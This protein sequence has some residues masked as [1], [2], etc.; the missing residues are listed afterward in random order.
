MRARDAI[1]PDP[2]TVAPTTTLLQFVLAVLDGNQ[3]TA[4]VVDAGRLVGVVSV[5]DVFR[6]LLPHYVGMT[7]SLATILHESY[8][9]EVF[10]RF[11]NTDVASVM[12]RDVDSIA[13]DEPLMHAVEKFVHKWRKTLPVIDG[14]RFVGVVTRRSVL[15]AATRLAGA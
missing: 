15:A 12:S 4:S 14:G 2:L 5:E 3:T 9:E 10:E 7:G 8:F 1:I 13:P 6:R 11:K